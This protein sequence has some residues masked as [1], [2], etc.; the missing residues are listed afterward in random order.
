M[1]RYSQEL[2]SY[3]IRQLN[4]LECNNTIHKVLATKVRWNNDYVYLPGDSF[5]INDHEFKIL[6]IVVNLNY[7]GEMYTFHNIH[8]TEYANVYTYKNLE[9]EDELPF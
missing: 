3:N 4:I 1:I 8:G 6:D 7:D 2:L 5:N 9:I